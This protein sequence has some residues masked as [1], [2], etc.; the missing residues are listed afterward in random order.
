MSLK[1]QREE[2][3]PFGLLFGPTT[4]H[5]FLLFDFATKT[6]QYVIKIRSY[7]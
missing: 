4:V 6:K 2:S 5:N 7:Q 3:D 1:C